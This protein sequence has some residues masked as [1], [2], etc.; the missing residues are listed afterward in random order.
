[1]VHGV[2]WRWQRLLARWRPTRP[3]RIGGPPSGNSFRQA[4]L[5]HYGVADSADLPE[6]QKMWAD[7][8][9]SAAERGFTAMGMLGGAYAL[10]GKRVL[11]VGCGYG[12][13][14]VAAARAGA[15]EV[16]GI[17]MNPRVLELAPLLLSDYEVEAR[18][19]QANLIESGLPGE[20]GRFDVIICNDVLEHVPDVGAAIANLAAMLATEGRI[21]LEIPNGNALKYVRADGHY[22]IPGITLLDFA[23]ARDLHQEF[24]PEATTY[25]TYFYGTLDYYLAAFSRHGIMLRLLDVPPPDEAAIESLAAE[26]AELR[27]ESRQWDDRMRAL[28]DAYLALVDARIARFRSLADRNERELVGMSLRISYEVGNWLLEG[29]PK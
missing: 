16:V 8:T 26:V 1:M 25:D 9:L 6:T 14:L 22:K 3:P 23:D 12:G 21:F 5:T 2:K 27:A 13:F 10:R 20:L 4:V 28:V 15:R 24:F 19:Q 18:L 17:D 29:R 11:D 7:F